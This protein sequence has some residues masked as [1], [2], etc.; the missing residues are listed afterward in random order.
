VSSGDDGEHDEEEP[1]KGSGHTEEGQ[2][3]LERPPG[4]GMP[5]DKWD[6]GG[7]QH[8]TGDDVESFHRQKNAP[9]RDQVPAV[10]R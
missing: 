4:L 1:A 3:A 6:T 10:E 2:H 8:Q 5:C 9:V 7:E